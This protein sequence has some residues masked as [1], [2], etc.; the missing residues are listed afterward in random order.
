VFVSVP[1]GFGCSEIVNSLNSLRYRSSQAFTVDN[2]YVFYFLLQV[3]NFADNKK[4]SIQKID[5]MSK[6][7]RNRAR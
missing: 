4:E 2:C 3:W 6:I 5:F 7:F 1:R